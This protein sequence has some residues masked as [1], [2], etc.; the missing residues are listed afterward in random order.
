M[1]AHMCVGSFSK[2]LCVCSV[3]GVIHSL[4]GHLG[5]K[6]EQNRG[7]ALGKSAFSAGEGQKQVN[8]QGLQEWPAPRRE[9][10]RGNGMEEEDCLS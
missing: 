6:G 7:S 3:P 2:Y 1:Y 9:V 4:C 10:R 5:Y 8:I